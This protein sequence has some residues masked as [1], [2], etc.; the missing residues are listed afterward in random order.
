MMPTEE[1]ACAVLQ[2]TIGIRMQ[3]VQAL[4]DVWERVPVIRAHHTIADMITHLTF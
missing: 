2:E 1:K 4:E 3:M